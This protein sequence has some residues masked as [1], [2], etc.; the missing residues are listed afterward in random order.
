ML[1]IRVAEWPAHTV[2]VCIVKM[3]KRRRLLRI[4]YKSSRGVWASILITTSMTLGSAIVWRSCG[5]CVPAA[6][7]SACFTRS[8][9]AVRARHITSSGVF[10]ENLWLDW[11]D[12][13]RRR[14]PA[15]H[16]AFH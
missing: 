9:I 5:D 10:D 13:H 7:V 3:R 11:P 14:R 4:G 6:E 1:T 16:H 12:I 8:D 15:T 2:P